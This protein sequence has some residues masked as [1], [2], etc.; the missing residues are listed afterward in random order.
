MVNMKISTT[1]ILTWVVYLL[2]LSSQLKAQNLNNYSFSASVGTYSQLSST[3]TRISSI[4]ADDAVSTAIP[5]GFPFIYLGKTYTQIYATSN[6]VI[7]LGGIP[8]A[9]ESNKNA[10]DYS[11]TNVGASYRPILTPLWNDL[12]GGG[13]EAYYETSGTSGNRVFSLEFR[14]WKWRFYSSAT[15]SMRVNLYEANGVVEMVYRQ[16]ASSPINAGGSIGITGENTGSF[17]SLQNTST[18]ATVSN[19][20]EITTLNTRPITGQIYKFSPPSS[21]ISAPSSLSLSSISRSGLTVSWVDQSSNETNFNVLISTDNVNFY[22]PTNGTITSTSQA[23]TGTTYNLNITGLSAGTTYYIQVMANNEGVSSGKTSTS[24]ST[25][26]GATYIWNKTSGTNSFTDPNNWTPSRTSTDVSDRLIFSNGGN[27]IVSNVPNQTVGQIE[28]KNL[29]QV[30][31]TSAVNSVLRVNGAD[32]DDIDIAYGSSLTLGTSS[33]PN[34]GLGYVNAGCTGKVA[35][36]LIVSSSSTFDC[37]NG[38]TSIYTDG[39]LSNSNAISNSTISNLVFQ[40]SSYFIHNTNSN[41][42]VANFGAELSLVVTGMTWRSSLNFPTQLGRLIWNSTQQTS[43]INVTS[44]TIS[45]LFKITSTGWGASLNL[46]GN[47]ICQD[48]FQLDGGILNMGTA[49]IDVEIRGQAIINGGTWQAL[50]SS[51]SKTISINKKF[52]QTG[53]TITTD[54]VN[55]FVFNLKDDIN[56]TSGTINAVTPGNININF[57]AENDKQQVVNLSGTN[58]GI[59]NYTIQNGTETTTALRGISLSN[60]LTLNSGS[61]I[62]IQVNG[63]GIRGAGNIVYSANTTLALTCNLGEQTI[64]NNTWG[65]SFVPEIV[66]LNNPNGVKLSGNKVLNGTLSLTNTILDLADN[67]LTLGSSATITGTFSASNMIVSGSGELKKTFA[68][69]NNISFIFPTGDQT[70]TV[71]FSPIKIELLTNSDQRTIGAKVIDGLHPNNTPSNHYITR[72]WS[73]SNSNTSGAYECIITASYLP[74]DVVGSEANIAGSFKLTSAWHQLSG[75]TPTSGNLNSGTI[76][77]SLFD[78]GGTD[79]TGRKQAPFIWTGNINNLWTQDGNWNISGYPNN[80]TTDDVILL[81]S[82]PNHPEISS[83]LIK[84]RT[85]NI[86]STNT[87]LTTSGGGVLIIEDTVNITNGSLTISGTSQVQSNKKVTINDRIILNNSAKFTCLSDVECTGNITQNGTSVFEITSNLPQ[88]IKGNFHS[89]NLANG[90]KN[91]AAATSLTGVLTIVDGNVVLNTNNWLKLASNSTSTGSIGP[92]PSGA[93]INGNTTIERFIPE[94][95][96]GYRMLSPAIANFTFQ[97]LIDDLLISGI[98]GTSNGFDSTRNNGG[99]CYT[100]QENTPTRGWHEATNINNSITAGKGAIV[101]VRGDRTL[102]APNWFTPP[103]PTQNAVTID[104]IGAINQGTI[105]IPLT[106]SST[107]IITNDGWNLI[108]NPFPSPIDWDNSGITKTNISNI[109]YRLNPATG[110]YEAYN[111]NDQ[112]YTGTMSNII[113]MSQGIFVQS[114]APGGSITINESAKTNQNA[115]VFLKSALNTPQIRIQLLKDTT[116]SDEALILFSTTSSKLY[117][118]GEDAMKMKNTHVNIYCRS[119]DNVPLQ[120]NAYGALSTTDSIWL[121]IESSSLGTHQIKWLTPNY[122]PLNKN[123]L[124]FDGYTGLSYDMRNLNNITFNIGSNP[125]SY[126]D[127]RF[128]IIINN[129][130]A[131]PLTWGNFHVEQKTDDVLLKWDTKNESQTSHFIIE[132]SNDGATFYELAQQKAQGKSSRVTNYTYMDLNGYKDLAIQQNNVAYYRIKQIDKNGQYSYSS[133][134]VIRD[135]T[136]DEDLSA[137]PIPFS[138]TIHLIYPNYTQDDKMM[139]TNMAGTELNIKVTHSPDGPSIYSEE[140]TSGVYVIKVLSKFGTPY[141][142]KV[143][144]F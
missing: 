12:G 79:F 110:S 82:A 100:Y 66:T 53:G 75:S 89:L 126:G 138:N 143:T 20:V 26:S 70:G 114:T 81:N 64:S 28:V 140:F 62:H 45:K 117:Q 112:S 17:L 124:L 133:I 65:E 36:G 2:T 103:F 48:S 35:G 105:N 68:A 139:V 9:T 4:E 125:L 69:G 77:N 104:Y 44:T 30:T 127:K 21:A 6:G 22:R 15:L 106:Y 3:A 52:T 1:L 54:G 59:I 7:A 29:T 80:P 142:K 102:P 18:S 8:S 13:S 97:Q 40:P 41:L 113:P 60:N 61:T 63:T 19:S 72:Y 131:L 84:I 37:L 120:I 73:L 78:I 11:L 87:N 141:T 123:V 43:S 91:I 115:F 129:Q 136:F 42:P 116:K 10:T 137:W 51:G 119:S 128:C 14:N 27:S 58:S 98:G 88:A 5:L 39:Y 93:Q 67:N 94:G 118:I 31:F 23:S 56:K 47:L 71:E 92:I 85:L 130:T 74:A 122:L 50:T 33:S 101:F 86:N 90:V 83:G 57:V 76:S 49:A 111:G 34:I 24:C 46:I 95:N 25:L 134:G 32:G 144:R 96:R 121:S 99:T 38:V 108:G 107:G 135:N 55:G 16:E 132:K 109:I